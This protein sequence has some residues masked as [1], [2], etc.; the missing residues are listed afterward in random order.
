MHR[1]LKHALWLQNKT[2]SDYK[3]LKDFCSL[4]FQFASRRNI[5]SHAL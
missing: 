5:N 4:F 1:K 2:D 3:S